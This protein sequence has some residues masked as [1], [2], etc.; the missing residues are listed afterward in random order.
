MWRFFVLIRDENKKCYNISMIRN[1]S[2]KTL[3]LGLFLAIVP[4]VVNA[5]A[6][7]SADT[8]TSSPPDNSVIEPVKAESATASPTSSQSASPRSTSGA[9]GQITPTL[10]TTSNSSEAPVS[11]TGS[12]PIF[13]G[14]GAVLLAVGYGILRLFR[15]K[16]VNKNEESGDNAER[17]EP[18]KE[19][20]HGKRN[21]LTAVGLEMSL[22]DTFLEELEEKLEEKKSDVKGKVKDRVIG[23]ENAIRRAIDRAEEAKET[24]DEI[25]EQVENTK[26]LLLVLKKRKSTLEEELVQLENSYKT[27]MSGGPI[28]TD[29]DLGEEVSLPTVKSAPLKAI[30]ID[31]TLENRDFLN[32]TRIEKTWEEGDWK[33]YGV[34]MSLKDITTLQKA[35]AK[36]PWYV[37]LWKDGSD[38]VTVV[39]KER[40]FEIDYTDKSTW[41]DAIAYGKF[42]GIPAEELDFVIPR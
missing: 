6:D 20:I 17:C 8:S 2:Y 3:I 13:V 34:S 27:C 36:G 30:I 26:K 16:K 42:I 15:S 4:F 19:L 25:K 31:H 1:F 33:A 21:E 7:G 28:T 38:I 37:H 29:I 18:I 41:K 11:S 24:Y 35:M 5:Q 22:K 32:K 9:I 39:F 10:G 23:K 14:S 12:L 40:I